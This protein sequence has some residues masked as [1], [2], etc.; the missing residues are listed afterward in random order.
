MKEAVLKRRPWMTTEQIGSL[1]RELALFLSAFKPCFVQDR[2]FEH[3][4]KYALGLLSDV[5]RKS[6]EPIALAAG[7]AV[8]TLQAFLSRFHWDHERADALIHRMVAEE[9]GTDEAIAVIDATSHAKRGDKTPGVQRQWCG[10]TGKNDNCVVS[11]CLLFTDNHPT[12]PFTCMLACDLFLPESWS[13]DRDR[14]REAGIPED[15]VHRPKW[16]IA[17]EQLKR[18]IGHGV[19]F[20]WATFD[21]DYGNVPEFWFSLD[22]LGLWGAGEVRPNFNAWATEPAYQSQWAAHAPRRVDN[23]ATYSPVFTKQQWREGKVKTTTRGTM[24]LKVKSALVQL[25]AEPSESRHHAS[26]PTDRRYWLLVTRNPETDET[27]YIVSN[28]P[29]NTPVET[30]LQVAF[31]RWHIEKWFE[32]AKQEAG[33]GAFEVRT[34]TSL[35]RHWLICRMVTL[36]LAR[37][38]RRLR[39]EKPANHLRTN[40]PSEQRDC[41]ESLEPGPTFAAR[42]DAMLPLLSAAQ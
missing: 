20:K 29:A 37:Q 16:K 36:F 41:M 38:T 10:E 13:N 40:R 9:H 25:V 39:G 15:L 30:I 1:E 11:Q 18:A 27:R 8:R 5:P 26:R 19:R 35:I 23:L 33:L 7:T 6:V 4:Q 17:I 12:N 14:C 3:L 32:R 31:A 28:A 42:T 2:T 22:A 34:Y 24:V 21:E